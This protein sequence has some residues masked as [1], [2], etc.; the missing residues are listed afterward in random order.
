MRRVVSVYLPHWSTDRLRRKTAKPPPDAAPLSPLVTAI[1]DHGRRIV[2][3]VDD[4]ARSLGIVPGMTITKARSF[5]PGL[6]VVDADPE[7]DLLGLRGIALWAGQRYAPIV[8]PDPPDGLWLD[9]TGC[10]A[11]FGNERALVKDLHRRL[12]A[13]GLSVQIAIADTAGCAHAVAR[14]VPAGRPVSIEPGDHRKALGLLPIGALRLEANVVEALRKLGFERI[15]QLI[16]APRAPLAKRFGR[17]LYWRL[18][19]ALGHGPE[20]ITP[21]F[22][23]DVPH[24]RRG[25][26]EPIM[27]AEAF[28]HVIGDLTADLAEQLM[29]M[30][31]G[32]RRL[33]CYF[34]RVDGNAQAV[35]IGTA[36]P[37]RDARHLAKLLCARIETID[38]GLGVEAMMLVASLVEPLRAHQGEELTSD[39]R[40]GPDLAT[41]VDALANRFGQR[42]LYRA[43][44]KA[45]AMP[46]RSVALVPPLAAAG[47][48]AWNGDL[49]RPCRML[50][51]PEAIDVTAMLPDHPPAMFSWRGKRFRVTQADGPERLHGEWWRSNGGEAE[52]PYA[53]RDYFQVETTS[54]GRYWI[55]RLGDGENPSTGPMRW[56]LHGAFA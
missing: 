41:L 54:G 56:F 17:A 31:K 16:G 7:A 8:A 48:G 45:S 33:D 10:A 53:V 2:A 35:R 25:F 13:F 14:H 23:E 55:F 52:R 34:H 50:A 39:I 27:T 19:Q 47:A 4:A 46:E 37:S 30:G 3:A 51:S 26:L 24:A 38:P 44:P 11:L 49:P 21:L 40:A 20:P 29:R 28:A 9:V 1:P 36:A 18:D 42:R 32:A 22:P 6:D 12:A 5:V 43:T 15:E